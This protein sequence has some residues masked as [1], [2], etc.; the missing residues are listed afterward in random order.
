M[1]VQQEDSNDVAVDDDSDYDMADG[2]LGASG[3]LEDVPEEG[4]S[5]SK[6]DAPIR[7][8]I[9]TPEQQSAL[10]ELYMHEALALISC[11]VLP[12][13]GAYLLHAIRS[14][15]S[16]PS[17]GLVSN[18]NLT[19]FLLVAELRTLSH[20]I[21]LVQA[22]T[23]H[24][25][26][27]VHENPYTAGASSTTQVA[28]LLR[29][30]Q[31]LE[32]RSPLPGPRQAGE[33]EP[34]QE[35]TITKD[36]R[37]AIQ[38]ELDALNR[39]MR[40]YE[41]RSTLLQ[42]QTDARFGGVEGRLDDAIALAAAAVKNSSSNNSLIMRLLDSILSVIVWPFNLAAQ[43]LSLPMRPITALFQSKASKNASASYVNGR[44]KKSSGKILVP[45]RY[46]GDRMPSRPSKR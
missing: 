37:A 13:V 19:V 4:G 11:F 21:K 39:A 31:L 28:D 38:P 18:F 22:R 29:R 33:A 45:S 27:V 46:G 9:V 36:V 35:V 5:P 30:V 41:K 1:R 2:D 20:M 34:E 7:E 32:G 23:L 43:I 44:G 17:E 10:S 6:T 15:L 40:R 24:L 3:S 42:H 16:R 14:Q 25:Q 12:L 26:R 8:K